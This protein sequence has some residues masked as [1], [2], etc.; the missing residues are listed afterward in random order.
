ML[1]KNEQM[2]QS[3]LFLRNVGDGYIQLTHIISDE[4]IS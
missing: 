3:E 2:N 4:V 1:Y